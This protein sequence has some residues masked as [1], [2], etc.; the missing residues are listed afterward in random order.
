MASPQLPTEAQIGYGM[1]VHIM[2]DTSPAVY[3]EM[4]EV[5]TVTPP[6]QQVDQVEATHS[7]SPDRTREFIAGL[8]D[9]GECSFE[10]NFVPGSAT[11]TRLLALKSSGVAKTTKIT[12]PN[13]VT[14]VFLA[15]VT[16]Y[17]PSTPIDDRMTVTV[18]MRVSGPTTITVPS[19]L[20]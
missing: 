9:P 20:P 8:N 5:I 14:W 19:P 11:D 10:M 3:E 17:E 1:M 6:N 16:G 7:Q 18:T 2:S 15:T 13:T 12:F 4:M